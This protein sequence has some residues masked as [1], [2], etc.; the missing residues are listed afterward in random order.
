MALNAVKVSVLASAL[1]LVGAAAVAFIRSIDWRAFARGGHPISG[2]SSA[3]AEKNG[4][5]C[6]QG[7]GSQGDGSLTPGAQSKGVQGTGAQSTGSMAL[8]AHGAGGAVGKHGSAPMA[9]WFARHR[10]TIGIL[11]FAVASRVLL[12]IVAYMFAVIFRDEQRGLID[13]LSSIW[14]RSDAPHYLD[15]AVEGYVTEGDHANFLVFLPFYPL[16][17]SIAAVFVQNVFAAGLLLSIAP[18]M[19]ACVF[20]YKIALR[21]GYDEGAAF[22]A[23]KYM[24]VFPASFFVNGTFSEGLFLLLTALFFYFALAHRWLE[25]GLF[26]MLAAFTRYYG[27]LLAAPMAIEYLQSRC[28]AGGA[29]PQ[30]MLPQGEPP[31]HTLSQD[32]PPQL[33]LPHDM[34][35]Q[36]AR[37][38]SLAR[39]AA[40]AA[41]ILLVPAGTGMYLLVNYIV[42]GDALRFL[43]IQREHWHQSFG[44]F[45]DNIAQ[46]AENASTWDRV[47]SMSLF[48]PQLALV[49]LTVV[50][51]VYGTAVEFRLSMQVYLVAY[52]LVSISASWMLSFPRYIFGALPVFILLARAAKNRAADSMMTLFC[53][54]GLVYLTAAY[55]CGHFVY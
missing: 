36:H 37:P 49:A 45:S 16:L 6:S 30:R 53:S 7:A 32:E 50:L 20:V 54:V 24:V 21:M 17:V 39:L 4:S 26:G 9:A 51:L 18:F 48:A 12:Y 13:S 55:V 46:M 47:T 11:A 43:T 44:L 19:A 34:P 1:F 52:L 31:R 41:P 5:P 42:A 25:A 23:A 33:T 22:A 28:G 14:Q 35:P 40:G 29:L 15:M 3:V 38:A 27:I 10:G 8:G 2:D